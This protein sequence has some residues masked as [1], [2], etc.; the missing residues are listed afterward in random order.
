ML[1]RESQDP[2]LTEP[3]EN[4]VSFSL[5]SARVAAAQPQLCPVEFPALERSPRQGCEEVPKGNQPG[6]GGK[7]RAGVAAKPGLAW[8][9]W[10]GTRAG[11]STWPHSAGISVTKSHAVPRPSQSWELG[12]GCYCCWIKVPPLVGTDHGSRHTATH[13]LTVALSKDFTL[14]SLSFLLYQMGWWSGH[15]C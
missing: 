8:E 2:V 6:T 3:R 1:G 11:L 12:H 7:L 4:P 15:G 10:A 14:L 13:S 9:A 5:G